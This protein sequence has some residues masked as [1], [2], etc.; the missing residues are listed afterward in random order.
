MLRLPRKRSCCRSLAAVAALDRRLRQ[1]AATPAA[2]HRGR[3]TVEPRVADAAV[4]GAIA[5]VAMG[6]VGTRYR[7][8]GTDPIEGFDCSGLVLLRLQP[9]GLPRPAHLARAVPRRAQDRGRRRRSRRPDVLPGPDE[10]IARRH[11]SGRRAVRARARERPER[12]RREPRLAVLSRAPRRRRPAVAALR[13]PAD[14]GSRRRRREPARL[15]GARRFLALGHR[16][17]L[18]ATLRR[19]PRSRSS[20]RAVASSLTPAHAASKRLLGRGSSPPLAGSAPRARTRA[21]R[22][23]GSARE[24]RAR[25]TRGTRR[26]SS[27]SRS[28]VGRRHGRAARQTRSAHDATERAR[29]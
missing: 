9:G 16:R 23:L 19:M 12:R 13:P 15:R 22:R 20:R 27:R 4:G 8:G 28:P 14:C 6:M 10:A 18:R 24:T 26:T 1:R 11:L 3:M 17:A 5:D 25:R 2:R 7:Y 21:R 29:P